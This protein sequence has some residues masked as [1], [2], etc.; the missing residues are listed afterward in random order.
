[1][2]KLEILTEPNPILHQKAKVVKIFDENLR[3]LARD[4]SETLFDVHGTIGLAAPQVGKLSRLIAVEFD[5]KRYFSEKEL[6]KCK[7]E[8]IPLTVL[9]NPKITWKSKDMD[10]SEEG[11]L[12][13]PDIELPIKRHKEIHVLAQ[14]IFGNKIKIRAKGYFARVIQHE[15]DHLEGILLTD[16]SKTRLN[17]IVFMGTPDFAGIILD[18]LISS[19]FKPYLIISESDKPSG[20]GNKIT[21]S[22]VK[23]LSI[24]NN[25]EIWQPNKINDVEKELSNLAPDLI[26]VAAYG[27]IIPNNILEISKFRA[28]NV[29][30]SL[31]PKF[32]G[33]TPIQGAILEGVKKTGVTIIKMDEKM[34]HGPILRQAEFPLGANITSSTLNQNLAH[35]GGNLLVKTIPLYILKNLKPIPQNHKEATFT[36]LLK[37]DDGI[38][39]WNKS[40]VEIDRQIKAYSPWPGSYTNID[41]K[42][43][44]ILKTHIENNKLIIDR[45][46]LEG[47]K[48]ISYQ[49]F[50]RGY[51]KS[52]DFLAKLR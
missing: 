7:E 39:D 34:D 5:P 28:I 38:I 15:I 49:E 36:K 29:H 32:R 43:L 1:M 19:P 12:S 31:L 45:V 17:R 50:V 25:I 14:D 3:K 41:N 40:P 30:P 9:V 24:K 33:A 23:L 27:Q 13:L 22:P 20:R 46:Q 21:Y 52:L 42:R 16:I 37:K 10:I 8:A 51:K 18:R 44:K 47:K 4:I 26:I 6:K 35:L 2:S 11:C 48:E